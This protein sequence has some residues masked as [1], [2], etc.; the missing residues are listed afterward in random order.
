M[1]LDANPS[2]NSVKRKVI[3]ETIDFQTM[4]IPTTKLAEGETKVVRDGING[5]R[6]ITYK[7]HQ[8]WFRN[9]FRITYSNVITKEAQPRIIQIGVA[10]DL[11][12]NQK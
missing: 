3:K 5:E 8:I 11:V 1:Y 10:K 7:V 12:E 2:G 6:Q 4:Y 9:S